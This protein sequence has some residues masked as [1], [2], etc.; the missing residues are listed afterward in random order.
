MKTSRQGFAYLLLTVLIIILSVTAGA[1]IYWRVSQGLVK[2]PMY[3]KIQ[4]DYQLESAIILAFHRIYSAGPVPIPPAFHLDSPRREII[5]GAFLTVRYTKTSD[6]NILI[7]SWID[8]SRLERRM[9]ARATLK[10][11]LTTEVVHPSIVESTTASPTASEAGTVADTVPAIPVTP[12]LMAAS[13]TWNL[14]F[15]PFPFSES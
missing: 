7:E 3:L 6:R 13:G 15:I 1:A 2:P 14:E 11:L 12:S 9:A 4:A 10:A 8:G 5:P